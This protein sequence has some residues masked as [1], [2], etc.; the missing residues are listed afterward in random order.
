MGAGHFFDEPIRR[1]R[2]DLRCH[3]ITNVFGFHLDE[4]G[5]LDG[6]RIAPL[7]TGQRGYGLVVIIRDLEGIGG[8]GNAT[9]LC[10]AFSTLR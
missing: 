5:Y 2:A 1:T 4:G 3:E 8:H 7:R 6:G 9:R 10:N